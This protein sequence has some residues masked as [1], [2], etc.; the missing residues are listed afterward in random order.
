MKANFAEKGKFFTEV[1][2]K[3]LLRAVIQTTSHCIH[4]TIHVNLGERL[5]DDLN[6]SNTFLALTDAEIIS[7]SGELLYH[8]N[9]L[10]LNRDYIV[11][12][13]PEEDANRQSEETEG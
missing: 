7:P 6:H 3:D 2:S 9:F 13:V 4:A 1:V 5:V 12:I 11:W 8:R 10:I